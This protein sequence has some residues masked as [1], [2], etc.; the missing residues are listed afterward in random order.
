ML[1]ENQTENNCGNGKTPWETF[2]TC[3]EVRPLEV[4]LDDDKYAY[5]DGG[6]CYEVDPR[7]FYPT[8]RTVFGGEDGDRFESMAFDSRY[9]FKNDVNTLAAFATVDLNNGRIHR[10]R[11]DPQIIKQALLNDG[12]DFSDILTTPNTGQIDYLH[13]LRYVSF[14]GDDDEEG[15]GHFEWTTDSSKARES[16]KEYFPSTEGIDCFDGF[17][18]FVSKKKELLFILDLDKQTFITQSTRSGLFQGQPDQVKRLISPSQQYEI[19]FPDINMNNNYHNNNNNNDEL[20]YFLE[21]GGSSKRDLVMGAGV[22]A[23]DSKGNYF[24]IA[25]GDN[26][27]TDET[28]GLAFCDEGKRLMFAFQDEGKLYELTRSDGHPFYG[29]SLDVTY[30]S[31]TQDK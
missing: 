27:L 8:K 19:F 14:G 1:L 21:D 22:H 4:K 2:I 28:T 3:E 18:Y 29:H 6:H 25:Q 7:K 20:I 26:T 13:I 23:R 17:L 24:T 9:M 11:A 15:A 31:P 16:A 12:R 10:Y 5:K 30:H